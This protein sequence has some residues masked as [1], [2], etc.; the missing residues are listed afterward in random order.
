[1]LIADCGLP[2]GCGVALMRKFNAMYGMKG[3][4]VSGSVDDGAKVE[5]NGFRFLAKP[6][7]VQ[8]LLDTLQSL[9]RNQG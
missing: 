6:V 8:R 9:C 5:A 3:I 7:D 1:M 4:L 2:D